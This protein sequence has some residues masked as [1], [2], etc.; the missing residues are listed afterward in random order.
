MVLSATN[1]SFQA[2]PMALPLHQRGS[3]GFQL[4]LGLEENLVAGRA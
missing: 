4:A 2:R 3:G 1:S